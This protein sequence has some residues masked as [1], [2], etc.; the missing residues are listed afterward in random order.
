MT[1][2]PGTTH[3]ATGVVTVHHFQRHPIHVPS[4]R[5]RGA[6]GYH[7]PHPWGHHWLSF[8]A[9]HH[10]IHLAEANILLVHNGFGHLRE[11]LSH[12]LKKEEKMNYFKAAN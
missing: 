8:G 2:T 1:R 12:I 11:T 5:T 6:A 7:R 10:F 9:F 3:G 4:R